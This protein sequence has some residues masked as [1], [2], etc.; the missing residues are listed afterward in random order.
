MWEILSFFSLPLLTVTRQGRLVWVEA[1]VKKFA[2]GLCQFGHFDFVLQRS[3]SPNFKFH[4]GV[5]PAC[6]VLSLQVS[7]VPEEQL[8]VFL[9]PGL[10]S[11][12]E[13]FI[14][15]DDE[16]TS[17]EHKKGSEEALETVRASRNIV[18]HFHVNFNQE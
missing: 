16:H 3:S 7:G 1:D 9:Y 4:G 11:T 10:P 6:V 8:L 14:L 15:P 13:L 5:M 2:M 17:S 18:L 12:A